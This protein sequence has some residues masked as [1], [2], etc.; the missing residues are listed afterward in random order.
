MFRRFLLSIV[1]FLV[2]WFTWISSFNTA[3]AWD[4]D[5]KTALI[6]N[7]NT[8]I[9]WTSVKNDNWLSM[10]ANIF[11][12]VKDSLTSLIVIVAVAAFLFI[13]A[14][15]ALARW[16]PEEFKK[17]MMQLVYAIVWIFIV[18]VAWAAVYLVSWLQI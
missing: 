13:W 18:S 11:V 4:V 10:L 2:I 15:L 12:W 5:I 6:E 14:R 16:N 1:F 17:G 8:D 7:T 3:I 9:V